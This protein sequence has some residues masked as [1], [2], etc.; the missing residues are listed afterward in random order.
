MHSIFFNNFK[1]LKSLVLSVIYAIILGVQ[2]ATSSSFSV[3]L[4]TTAF[5]KW[6]EE[7]NF[8][9][10]IALSVNYKIEIAQLSVCFLLYLFYPFV[11]NKSNCLRSVKGVL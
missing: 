7:R 3:Q 10:K 5:L 6:L 9:N 11:S 1:T 4:R 2:N 8:Q